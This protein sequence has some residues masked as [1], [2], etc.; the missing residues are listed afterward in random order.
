MLVETSCIICAPFHAKYNSRNGWF[1]L[2]GAEARFKRGRNKDQI[3]AYT[4][5]QTRQKRINC[6]LERVVDLCACAALLEFH[7]CRRQL[8]LL[9]CNQ[10][11]L[12]LAGADVF[13]CT[14]AVSYEYA[15]RKRKAG[16]GVCTC[17]CCIPLDEFDIKTLVQAC[18]HG[19]HSEQCPQFFVPRKICFKHIIK[20]KILSQKM[21]LPPKP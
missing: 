5:C 10:V 20:A 13:D 17:L 2:S 21:Y 4:T 19:G 9:Q 14:S 15:N 3:D 11:V 7:N 16:T 6:A 1:C 12:Q 18:N 8:N